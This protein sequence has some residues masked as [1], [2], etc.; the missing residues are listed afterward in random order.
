[1]SVKLISVV[2][3]FILV[4]CAGRNTDEIVANL[5]I[6]SENSEAFAWRTKLPSLVV[7][8]AG[9]CKPCIKEIPYIEELK[10]KYPEQLL[11]LIHI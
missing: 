5:N 4:S 3:C 6:E 8:A 10:Q 7:F 11:S 1:M 9:W 2:F